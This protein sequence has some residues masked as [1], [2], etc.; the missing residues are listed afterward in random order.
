MRNGACAA[1][2]DEPLAIF[3]VGGQSYKRLAQLF[4]EPYRIQR[5]VLCSPWYYRLASVFKRFVST[6]GFV[7]L[8]QP[9]FRNK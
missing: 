4:A 3:E 7:V 2:L 6:L 5:D 8:S 1:Y 9:F